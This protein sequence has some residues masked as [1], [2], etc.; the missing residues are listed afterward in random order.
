VQPHPEDPVEPLRGLGRL[1]PFPDGEHGD[2]GHARWRLARPVA[3]QRVRGVGIEEV[4]D[5]RDAVLPRHA[6]DGRA[7]GT[8]RVGVVDHHRPAGGEVGSHQ[9]LLAL[10]RSSGM[11]HEILADVRVCGREALLVETRLARCRQ[12]DQNHDFQ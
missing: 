4:G 8:A 9:L 2:V 3:P 11:P 7:I 10:L 5:C 12:A 1:E 6:Q